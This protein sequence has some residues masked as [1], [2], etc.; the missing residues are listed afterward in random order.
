A[1]AIALAWMPYALGFGSMVGAVWIVAL[2]A[3]G[4][5]I[6]R[7]DAREAL[8]SKPTMLV[9]LGVYLYFMAPVFATGQTGF[10]GYLLLGDTSVNFSVTD[11]VSQ[12][13]SRII[14][15]PETSYAAAALQLLEAGYPLG[16][17]TLLA[18]LRQI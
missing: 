12:H 7:S 8:P 2:T 9:M 10:L 13:G 4:L 5:W 6:G 16:Q 18:S 1:A 17:H 15:M 14:P 11:Y 3:I